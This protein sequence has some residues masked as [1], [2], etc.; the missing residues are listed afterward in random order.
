MSEILSYFYQEQDSYPGIQSACKKQNIGFRPFL[1][2]EDLELAPL[3]GCKKY[4]L[5]LF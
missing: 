5:G 2:N 1:S 4:A 3:P